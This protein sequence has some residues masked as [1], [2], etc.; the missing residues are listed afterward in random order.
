MPSRI[1]DCVLAP[2][3]LSLATAPESHAAF[4]SSTVLIFRLSW[5][6]F[7]FLGPTPGSRSISTSP[8]RDRGAKLLE[9]GQP[10]GRDQRGDLLLERLA[11]AADLA[12]FLLLHHLLEVAAQL[13][14]GAG[15][16]VV[17]VG[18]EGVL[19]LELQKGADLIERS[20]D[21]V[22]R[23]EEPP[24]LPVRIPDGRTRAE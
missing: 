18:A 11:D 8:G 19:P 3:P 24:G 12:E 7:T 2:K 4:R 20:S 23:H 17:G 10:A 6:A 9:V 14:D 22:L 5:S 1:F 21:F 16:G 15:R 13:P